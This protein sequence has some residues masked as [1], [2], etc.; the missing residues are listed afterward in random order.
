MADWIVESS[1]NHSIFRGKGEAERMNFPDTKLCREIEVGTL[2]ARG[3]ITFSLWWVLHSKL[4]LFPRSSK[5]FEV[6]G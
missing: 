4:L 1:G 3:P 2:D 6:V 5:D